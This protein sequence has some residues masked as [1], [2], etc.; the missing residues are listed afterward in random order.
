MAVSQNGWTANDRTLIESRTVPG[1]SLP[2]RKGPAGDL[3]VYV[4]TQFH[5]RVE[6]LVW[7]G[8]WGY[9]ERQIIGGTEL[10]N[11][12]SG[13]AIDLNAPQHPLSAVGT[14]TTHQV[15]AIRQ[16]LS[17]CSGVIRWGGDYVGRKDEMHFEIDARPDDDAV[18]VAA[19]KLATAKKGRPGMQIIQVI[20]AAGG[21]REMTLPIAIGAKSALYSRAW[22]SLAADRGG[23]ATVWMQGAG[24]DTV[25]HDVTLD[26]DVRWW[27][28]IPDRTEVIVL[29]ADAPAS[30]GAMLEYAPK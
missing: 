9:A 6:H 13:T 22:L 29:H 12:A 15:G 19:A 5:G 27:N 7:P 21:H 20:E 4:A 28:E 14:F 30:L 24:M 11:H 2:V 3:L 25:R 16:I 26:Q 10:S 17:E 18:A 8:C 1:G 23:K